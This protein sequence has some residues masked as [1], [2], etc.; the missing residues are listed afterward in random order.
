MPGVDDLLTA[1]IGV[2]VLDRLESAAR[3]VFRPFDALRNSD[4]VAV[5]AAAERVG[6]MPFDA[7]LA[8]VLDAASSLAGPWSP[9][10]VDS[11]TWAY[12][13]AP[14]RRRLAEA[15]WTRFADRLGGP[16]NRDGQEY[17]LE[18][19]D[20]ARRVEPAFTGYHQ[21]YSSGEFTWAGVW[22]VTSPPPEIH[23]GLISA[24]E[25]TGR[26]VSRWRIPVRPDVRVWRIDQ[27]GDWAGL[28]ETFPRFAAGTHLGWA[29]PGPNQH[30]GE[31]SRLSAVPGQHAAS[32]AARPHLVPDW[33]AVADRY[34]GVHLSWAGFLTA[35]GFV[36]DLP[37]D[38]VVML[39]Y[40]GS[41]R[42]LWLHDVF[43]D[44]QPTGPPSLSGRSTTPRAS[45]SATAIPSAGSPTATGSTAA[46][47][48]R[49]LTTQQIY[50]QPVASSWTPAQDV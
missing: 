30:P 31:L 10:A 40:W 32:V 1:P 41:E 45:T 28:V 16:F 44:P 22:T 3:K 33:A 36:N 49:P 11:L 25:F 39:R 18:E 12:R 9:G 8:V 14:A 43:G 42:T 26:Q 4:P 38:G 24:W 13:L 27:P 50:A 6:S 23:D 35:E 34:D 15:V 19:P 37:D 21:G 17:W 48:A 46:S 47:D 20:P 29:L 2:A 7:F 5:G